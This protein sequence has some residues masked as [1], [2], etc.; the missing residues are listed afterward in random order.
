[1]ADTARIRRTAVILVALVLLLPTWNTEAH[2]I[3]SD[4]TVQA[5][6]RPEGNTMRVIV[7]V[8]LI[9]MRDFNWVVRD[10]GYLVMPAAEEMGRDAA[11]LWIRNFVTIYEG[12]QSLGLP[13]I[14]ATR[15]AVPGDGALRSYETALANVLSPPLPDG[16]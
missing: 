4:V 2:E 10:P 1:M 7:R 9:S 14:A 3:P 15:I 11:E 5:Y 6:I 8:P 16:T 13:D 12:G